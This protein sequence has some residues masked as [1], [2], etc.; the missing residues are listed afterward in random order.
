MSLNIGDKLYR[1]SL[2]RDWEY[3]VM[4]I[5]TYVN[6]ILY[7]VKNIT[8]GQDKFEFIISEDTRKGR[9]K[10][11]AWSYP[12]DEN[13]RYLHD[14][15]ARFFTSKKDSLIDY[16][17][18]LVSEKEKDIERFEKLVSDKKQDLERYKFNLQKAEGIL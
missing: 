6:S 12:D 11:S 18:L 4:G 10:F 3:E 2:C 7:H 9:Y 13:N 17:K 8:Q 15:S 1:I 16:Y 14:D 5:H